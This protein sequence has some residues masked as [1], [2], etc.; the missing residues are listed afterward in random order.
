MEQTVESM[1]QAQLAYCRALEH[2]DKIKTYI[3]EALAIKSSLVHNKN[4]GSI[5]PETTCTDV[6]R[7][8]QDLENLYKWLEAAN[9][10]VE[11]IRAELDRLN[12][13]LQDSEY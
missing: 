1:S 4:I 13:A 11:H 8:C 2:Q 9:K 10:T 3:Q 6:E 5:G 7:V 12:A